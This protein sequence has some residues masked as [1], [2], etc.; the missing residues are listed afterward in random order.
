M[1][2]CKDDLDE[3]DQRTQKAANTQGHET[4]VD[5][6]ETKEYVP[7]SEAWT[8]PLYDWWQRT[9]GEGKQPLPL[10]DMR[11]MVGRYIIYFLFHCYY[12]QLFL[13]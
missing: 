2:I 9:I 3:K 10:K 13:L 11:T 8:P 5:T 4:G 6:T 7:T 12:N 1:F